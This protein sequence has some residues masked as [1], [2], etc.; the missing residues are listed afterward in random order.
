M[1]FVTDE[2]LDSLDPKR[3][4]EGN[5]DSITDVW[6]DQD[7]PYFDIE[8]ISD[9]SVDSSAARGEDGYSTAE[10]ERLRTGF[11]DRFTRLRKA[12]VVRPADLDRPA[13][14]LV[15]CGDLIAGRTDNSQ[16]ELRRVES[17]YTD[18][19]LPAFRQLQ[20]HGQRPTR[21]LSLP[22]NDDAYAGGGRVH[23]RWSAADNRDA[24]G[25]SPYY[26]H[27]AQAL[28]ANP[29][30]ARPQTHPVAAVFRAMQH[31]K[32]LD[33]EYS[34]VA[35]EPLAYVVVIGFD[36]NDIE[37]QH[38]LVADY[39]QVDAEQMQWSRRLVN[40]LRT[41]AARNAP[42]YVIAATHHNLLPVEDR[43]VHA[44]MGEQDERVGQL[45]ERFKSRPRDVAACTPLSPLCITNHLVAGNATSTTSNASGFLSHCQRLRTSL[46]LHGHMHQ[47]SATTLVS[48][49]LVAGQQITELSVLAAPAFAKDH[50]A[51]GMARISLDL[52][53]GEAEIAFKYDTGPDGERTKPVQITRRLVS[54]SR[55]SS[56]ERRLYGK[57]SEV[58]AKALA[59]DD[60]QHHRPA[61]QKYADHVTSA[62]NSAGYASVSLPDGTLPHLGNPTRQNRYYLLLLLRQVGPGSYEMLLSR[63]NPLRP[64]A[65][66]EW[67]TLL[68]PAF[69]SVR[70]LMERLHLDVVRQVVTQAED[71]EEAW[72]AT[73]FDA[74]VERIQGGQGNVQEDIWLD[75]MREL[76]TVSGEKI[77]PT[78]G[79]VTESEYRLVVLTPF[80][81]D[82]KSADP[83][84]ATDAGRRQELEDERTV[85][86]WFTEL[87]SLRLSGAATAGRRVYPIEAITSGGAGLRWEPTSDPDDP[88][89]LEDLDG[90]EEAGSDALRRVVLPPGSV[91]F[92]V[93][94]NDEFAPLWKTAPSIVARNADVMTWVDEQLRQRR[95]PD[96]SFP[97]HFVMGQM[98]ESTGYELREGPFPFDP[99]D[100]YVPT[101]VRA[102]AN[103]PLSTSSWEALD[104]VEYSDAHDLKNQL[105]YRGLPYRRLALVRRRWEVRAGRSRDVILVF[106]VEDPRRWGVDGSWYRDCRADRESGFVGI[107]RPA[108]R[109]VLKSGLERAEWVND[110]LAEKC[111]GDPWGFCRATYGGA[112]EPIALTPPIVEQVHPDD[113]DSDEED[114][115][116]YV[117]CDGNHRVVSKV[118][119]SG[120]VAA[121][122][123]IDGQPRQPYYA[124]PFS[125]YEWDLTADNILTVTP[126]APFRHAPRRVDP[127]ELGLSDE[128]VAILAKTSPD[129]WYR[130]YF[131][132]LSKGFG[133]MG[134]QGGRYV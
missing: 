102:S 76:A 95:R 66:A 69:S 56:S 58:V 8:V 132:D 108:Q 120:Q 134:G 96:G 60:Q 38:D 93:P 91:W 59:D 94:E 113:W 42:L 105:P 15:S 19:C 78:T 13:D 64:S 51:S 47:R 119:N 118:W 21:L 52:W 25:S 18:V 1:H 48:A 133:P 46:V 65:V 43:H 20:Q 32:P 97:P 81:R 84:Q 123:G 10:A 124:R 86:N 115:R 31:A 30:P 5:V 3:V 92:P 39:G 11:V 49:P 103:P 24:V 90:A 2:F 22:G 114:R 89:S 72:S 63:H 99:P 75:K 101:P 6:V 125:P 111:A 129:N 61:V 55:I 14:L 68:M 34:G 45:M 130:R 27:L 80:V 33:G 28:A 87:P 128:A 70:N 82:A 83:G 53:H 35:A 88:D 41:G 67:D 29:M 110:F 7:N 23:G 98:R 106:T 121:A 36:S 126:P 44:P 117:V 17:A 131:R 107:L 12:F 57:I 71:M 74:A 77:S 50:P 85:V 100:G 73:T 16:A 40:T 9:V 116:E 109:Y 4:A 62:W 104:R 37:Y 26:A 122:I 54:A 79:E 127:V 112:G